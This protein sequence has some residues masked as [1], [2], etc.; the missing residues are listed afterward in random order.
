MHTRSSRSSSPMHKNIKTSSGLVEKVGC[1]VDYLSRRHSFD[2]KQCRKTDNA[3]RFHT[4]SSPKT[5]IQNKLGKVNATT[6]SNDRISRFPDKF[7]Q[8]DVFLTRRKDKSHQAKMQRN[9]EAGKGVSKTNCKTH[10]KADCLNAGN[11]SS[12]SSKSVSTYVT[13]KGSIDRQILRTRDNSVPRG[14]IRVNLVGK[15]NRQSQREDN[16]YPQSRFRYNIG[17]I[18]RRLGSHFPRYKN[19]RSVGPNRIKTTHKCKRVGSC[20]SSSADISKRERTGSCSFEVGQYLS[21]CLY[22]P[23]G[24]TRSKDLNSVMKQ[25]WEW[26]NKNR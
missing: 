1:S 24:G 23:N 19:R 4:I 3:S 7:T 12:K 8:Y 17:R 14:K 2:S 9:V 26:C 25:F 15:S 16:K 22:K 6:I 13:N 20:I 5:G 11:T 10:R 21:G 18:K